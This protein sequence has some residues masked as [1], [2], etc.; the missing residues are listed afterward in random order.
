MYVCMYVCNAT[1]MQLLQHMSCGNGTAF[2]PVRSSTTT[3]L[4]E[5]RQ[6][7]RRLHAQ[8]IERSGS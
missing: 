6:Q 4:A 8:V 1:G 7:L 2:M 5:R 3:E